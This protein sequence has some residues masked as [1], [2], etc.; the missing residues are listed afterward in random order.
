[1]N[2]KS[3]PMNH[4]KSGRDMFAKKKEYVEKIETLH[5]LL[6]RNN[7]TEKSLNLG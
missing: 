7:F 2:H 6:K 4:R 1:M 5:F 3:T